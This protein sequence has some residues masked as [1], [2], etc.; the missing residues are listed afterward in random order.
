MA[1]FSD[2]KIIIFNN[3]KHLLMTSLILGLLS[4]IINS[5]VL[6]NN[7][8][9]SFVLLYILKIILMALFKTFS[10]FI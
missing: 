3:L 2:S 4:S 6:F 8:S 1:F 9:I 7:F 5:L 10:S